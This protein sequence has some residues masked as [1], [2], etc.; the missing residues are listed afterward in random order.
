MKKTLLNTIF[1]LVGVLLTSASF[2]Q[3]SGDSA[4]QVPKP[5]Q[6][7]RK[8]HIR[9]ADPMLIAILLSGVQNYNGSPVP[10]QL[11]ILS[12]GGFGGMNGQGGF[13]NSSNNSMGGFGGMN[14]QGGF[15]NSSGGR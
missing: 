7:V 15:G 12:Q 2:A 11:M 9:S 5:A 10:S 6:T 3:F 1:T 4:V 14:G 13:G 8:I